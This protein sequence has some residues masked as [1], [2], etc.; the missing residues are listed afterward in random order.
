LAGCDA[1]GFRV[2]PAFALLAGLRAAF[3]ERWGVVLRRRALAAF[4][5]T[6][7]RTIFFVGFRVAG[8]FGW[9]G[10]DRRRVFDMRIGL[11]GGRNLHPTA[12]P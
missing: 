4:F 12:P 5:G 11:Q 1:G 10:L 8:R 2:R 7:L 3:P 9:E 6:A